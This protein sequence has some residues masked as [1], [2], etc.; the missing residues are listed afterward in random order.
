MYY[1]STQ[2][3]FPQAARQAVLGLTE[4]VYHT[5]LNE[6]RIKVR[7]TGIDIF[8]FLD[9]SAALAANSTQNFH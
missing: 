7:Y 1:M 5:N 4:N 2:R 3:Q 6:K 8:L 9:S